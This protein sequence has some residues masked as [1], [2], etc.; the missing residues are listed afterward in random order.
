MTQGS[1]PDLGGQGQRVA[2]QVSPEPC[3]Q[4]GE[5][6]LVGRVEL[7]YGRGLMRTIWPGR[8]V[9]CREGRRRERGRGGRVD[10]GLGLGVARLGGPYLPDC[11]SPA[12]F[13]A[14]AW[15]IQPADLIPSFPPHPPALE[16]PLC[17]PRRLKALAASFA[18]KRKTRRTQAPCGQNSARSGRL[19]GAIVFP[20]PPGPLWASV[21]SPPHAT[22]KWRGAWQ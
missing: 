2:P 22:H 15:P 4:R 17:L 18:G 13:T 11:W 19:G 16:A 5:G 20:E 14:T 7:P 1:Y 21:S 6:S 12:A 3:G 8:S 10:G 9:G